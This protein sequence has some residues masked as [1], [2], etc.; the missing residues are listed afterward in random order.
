MSEV[1]KRVRTADLSWNCLN[2]RIVKSPYCWS[3]WMFI[4]WIHLKCNI[5]LKLFELWK[6]FLKWLF[7]FMIVFEML[8]LFQIVLNCWR[9]RIVWIEVWEIGQKM[10]E[11]H[12]R[13][14]WSFAA[15]MWNESSACRSRI[16]GHVFALIGHLYSN[17]LNYS[18]LFCLYVQMLFLLHTPL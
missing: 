12:N 18:L 15:Y 5:C 9:G 1:L 13:N 7:E 2:Y 6:T 16:T 17:D 3:C 11:D 8:N 14:L 4:S 10:V